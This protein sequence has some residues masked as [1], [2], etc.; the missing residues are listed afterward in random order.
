MKIMQWNCRALIGKWASV[1]PFLM[2]QTCDVYCLQET[3][4]LPTDEYDFNL[5]NYTRYDVFG[6]D[7]RRQGGVCIYVSNKIPHRLINLNTNLQAVACSIRMGSSTMHICSLYLPPTED[8]QYEELE[9]LVKQLPEPMIICTDANSRHMLWGSD[10]CDRRG[11]IWERLIRAFGLNVLNDGSATRIDDYTGLYSHIDLTVSSGSVAPHAMWMTEDDP[12]DSDHFPIY[13]TLNNVVDPSQDSDIFYGWNL[14]KANWNEFREKCILKYVDQLG[15][16]ENCRVMTDLIV[17]AATETIPKKTG[18]VKYC[19]PWWTDECKEAIRDRK[20]LLNRFRRNREV[21]GLLLEYKRAKAKARQVIRQAKK[22]SWLKLLSLFNYQTPLPRLWEILRKFTR[23]ARYN[24]P[25]PVLSIDGCIIDDTFEVGNALGR[26]FES[27]SSQ[28]NYSEHFCTRVDHII[29]TMPDFHSNNAE[30]Y[31][32]L[33]TSSELTNAIQR[34]GNTSIGPDR[35]HYAFFKHMGDTQHGELLKMYNAVWT[36]GIFPTEWSHSY[37]VPILKPGKP[38]SNPQSYRPIQLTSCMGKIMERMIAERLK[39]YTESK[40]MLSRY[41]CAF[42]KARCTADHIIRLESEIRHGFFYHKYTLAVFLDFKSAYNLVSTPALL[43]KMHTLGFRGRLM[44]FVK[45]Y[46]NGRTFQVKCGRLSQVF[47][48]ENGVVQG[49]VVS[50]ILF[51][52]MINDIFGGISDEFSHAMYAD[53]C[54]IW[55]QGRHLPQLITTMQN[56]LDSLVEWADKWGFTFTPTKCNAVIFGRY[57][58]RNELV[59]IPQLQ[60]KGESIAYCDNVKFLG[61]FLD[62]KLNLNKHIQYVR[63]R[64]LK[65]IPLLKCISGREY[66]A[67]RTILLKMYKSLIRPILEYAC[68]VLD[69]PANNAVHSLESIQNACLR[70]ATGALRTSPVMALQVETHVPPLFLRRWELTVRYALKV[71]G[72]DEHPCQDYINGTFSLPDLEWGYMKRISGF[73]FYERLQHVARNLRIV[74]P[75]D[76]T[77]KASAYP[78]WQRHQCDTRK[79]IEHR[80]TTL[81]RCDVLQAFEEFKDAHT[82]YHFLYTDGSKGERGV[83]CAFVHGNMQYKT[84]LKRRYSIFTAECVAMLQAV[85]Y[86]RHNQLANSVIC[87]DSL[88]MLLALQTNESNHPIVSDIKD[89]LHCLKEQNLLCVILWVPGHSGIY[90]NEQADLQAK[91][92]VLL[93]RTEEVYEVSVQEYVPYIRSACFDQ[94]NSMWVNDTRQTNLK[95]IKHVTGNWM[96]CRRKVRREEI[97]LCRLRLGHTRISHS[98]IIDRDVRPECSTCGRYV[99]VQHMLIE[100]PNY[101]DQR[102]RLSVLCRHHRAPMELGTLLG[103]SYPDIIDALFKFL[104]DSELIKKI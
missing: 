28:E 94:F 41:Q 11:M 89:T 46:L 25:L 5:L 79:L 3:H 102:R 58:K 92:A 73:P 6:N 93:D 62:S 49:G 82:G 39:W 74:L 77:L 70:I 60:I 7:E 99:T 35:L 97:V 31:N 103:D 33:F 75:D 68:Q 69:G 15:S 10:R 66:G 80:K 27:I 51:N 8:I 47:E 20:R 9:S 86:V 37:V 104:H 19:C 24:R 84:K 29:R 91:R 85:H 50:P 63:A 56:A 45:N 64:A 26:Y 72:Y 65:R 30:C 57:M 55:L 12:H 18:H 38:A 17:S 48:Q 21:P 13:V 1:K 83:G 81:E 95:S 32:D 53:D 67:D 42:R 34:C 43:L 88:S 14:N 36:E 59:N 22:D 87:T 4:F 78:V 100:C 52:L 98:F 71:T 61:V 23:K 2:S 90:G 40:G 54:A 44:K 101:A 16:V 76:V 96:S